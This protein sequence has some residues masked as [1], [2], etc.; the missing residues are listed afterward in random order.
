[1]IDKEDVLPVDEGEARQQML[2][3]SAWLFQP[4]QLCARTLPAQHL[5]V[6]LPLNSIERLNVSKLGAYLMV[7][8]RSNGQHQL[9][10]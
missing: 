10:T 4:E 1:M 3:R 5:G 8:L 6:V 9:R 7:H 2:R